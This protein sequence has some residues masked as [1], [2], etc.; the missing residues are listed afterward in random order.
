MPATQ[1]K[2]KQKM[3]GSAALSPVG[4]ALWHVCVCVCVLAQVRPRQ[5]ETQRYRADRERRRAL[6]RQRQRRKQRERIKQTSIQAV[7]GLAEHG[8]GPVCVALRAVQAGWQRERGRC[9]TRPAV[10]TR[11]NVRCASLLALRRHVQLRRRVVRKRRD[12]LA[13]PHGRLRRE[14]VAV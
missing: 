7:H 5:R 13:S 2:W 6:M 1:T 9:Q 12:C 4:S 14:A 10:M 11:L 3:R 8:N